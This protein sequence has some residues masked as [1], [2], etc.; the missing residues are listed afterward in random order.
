MAGVRSF[1][2]AAKMR[3]KLLKDLPEEDVFK[4]LRSTVLN[5]GDLNDKKSSGLKSLS[6]TFDGGFLT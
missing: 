3:R 1:K 6:E 4:E 2:G 5:Q